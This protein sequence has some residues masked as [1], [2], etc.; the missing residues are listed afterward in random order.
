M[1]LKEMKKKEIMIYGIIASVIGGLIVIL[2]I[3]I[4]SNLMGVAQEGV[5]MIG[6]I[7]SISIH[8][9]W[10]VITFLLFA[11]ICSLIAKRVW[12]DLPKR[13]VLKIRMDEQKK[14]NRECKSKLEAKTKEYND[15]ITRLESNLNKKIRFTNCDIK[16]HYKEG[17][18][19][20]TITQNFINMSYDKL[21]LKSLLLF[22]KIDGAEIDKIAYDHINAT[23]DLGKKLFV[24]DLPPYED[25]WVT[26]ET[27]EFEIGRKAI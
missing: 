27:T 24:S 18:P 3:Y 10:L 12:V 8:L 9:F 16:L 7:L 4:A 13:Y 5:I 22:V 11:L 23:F 20:I 15:S 1:M 21:V 6:E 17:N 19:K 14:Q 2:L 26:C 25:C